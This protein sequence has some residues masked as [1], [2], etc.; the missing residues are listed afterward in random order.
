[1]S[2][3]T[4]QEWDEFREGVFNRVQEIARAK[5]AD[6]T[7]GSGDPFANFRGAERFGSSA[8]LGLVLRMDDKFQR[9]A[10]Y[11]NN[12][13]L[14]VENEGVEDALYDLIGYAAIGLGL[15]E[16]QKRENKEEE[17]DI[18]KVHIWWDDDI[19]D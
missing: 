9:V 19:R 13:T 16:E 14:Q 4:M 7:A 11:L 2:K 17:I 1:M 18:P 10:A 5:N 12:G 8:L 15:L 3:M 6:Y